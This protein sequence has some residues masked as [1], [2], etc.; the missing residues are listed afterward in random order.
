MDFLL[1]AAKELTDSVANDTEATT[2]FFIF[3][4]PN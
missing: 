4:P 3:L 1:S 2:N